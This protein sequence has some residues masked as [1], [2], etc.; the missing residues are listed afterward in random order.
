MA[1]ATLISGASLLW[2]RSVANDHWQ[3]MEARMSTLEAER[4]ARSPTR[5][6]L[7]GEP[8]PG[9]AWED[10]RG[11]M[12]LTPMLSSEYTIGYSDQPVYKHGRRLATLPEL[13]TWV[14]PC[15]PAL[16]R[17]R[18]G[19]RKAE[20]R[21]TIAW[22]GRFRP[23]VVE[24]GVSPPGWTTAWAGI[25]EAR[26]LAEAGKSDLAA[27]LLL[28]LYQFGR[29]TIDGTN[30]VGCRMG[31]GVLDLVSRELRNELQAHQV[32]PAGLR[33]IDLELE[34]LDRHWPTCLATLQNE[35]LAFGRGCTQEVLQG[36]SMYGGE[37]RSLHGWQW[38]YSSRFR[39]ASTFLRA[40]AFSRS[41]LQAT[42]LK[43][44]SPVGEAMI[45]VG[46]LGAWPDRVL[47]GVLGEAFRNWDLIARSQLRLV[48]LAAHYQA[49]GEVLD[50]EDPRADRIK[51]SRKGDR[52]RAWSGGGTGT[53]QAGTDS[54]RSGTDLVI[55]VDR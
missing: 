39:A 18:A 20:L 28:D 54:W 16:D 40:D 33:R 25:V 9:N 4:A 5:P 1:V 21:P 3:R 45:A 17:L 29:D 38:G 37:T 32:S 8:N 27:E 49:T 23:L 7:R 50:L 13:L 15:K 53:V 48:R 36:S 14:A 6:V 10:Y 34:I 51:I 55:E 35:L 43:K 26:G 30:V 41:F 19:T 42:A 2:I 44:S 12:A 47:C 24:L 22:D 31:E 11:A 46:P 52:L